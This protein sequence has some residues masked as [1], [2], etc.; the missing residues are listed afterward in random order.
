MV[1]RSCL[2]L[3]FGCGALF[4]EQSATRTLATPTVP[5]QQAFKRAMPLPLPAQ[6]SGTAQSLWTPTLGLPRLPASASLG[7]GSTQSCAI[8]L[9]R[10]PVPPD[11]TFSMNRIPLHGQKLDRMTKRPAVKACEETASAHTLR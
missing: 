10:V 2:C 1:I 9:T 4:G 3:L 8:P 11:R 6:D 5:L 7:S